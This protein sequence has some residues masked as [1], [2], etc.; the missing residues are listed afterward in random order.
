MRF[1]EV[2]RK[3]EL[4]D[5]LIDTKN[6][7]EKLTSIVRKEAELMVEDGVKRFRIA[8]FFGIHESTFGQFMNNK[9]KLKYNTLIDI[10]EA[11]SK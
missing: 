4:E 3:N 6:N 1:P 11:I 2:T 9:I 5:I 8:K 7:L 10:A